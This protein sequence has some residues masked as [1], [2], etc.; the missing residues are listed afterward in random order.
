[1]N[2]HYY[3]SYA[4]V[5]SD[6]A[7]TTTDWLKRI[8]VVLLK[9][10]HVMHERQLFTIISIKWKAHTADAH[11]LHISMSK[12]EYK[13]SFVTLCGYEISNERFFTPQYT[14]IVGWCSTNDN[15]QQQSIICVRSNLFLYLHCHRAL[16][17]IAWHICSES[18]LFWAE[19]AFERHQMNQ[20][21][22]GE[23]RIFL[24]PTN[25]LNTNYEV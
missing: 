8:H 15:R 9:Q 20:Q 3:Y 10:F 12:T 23:I 4:C 14:I 25:E 16:F 11:I 17:A 22:S 18:V 24:H 19:I 13:S 2:K 1:M 5:T 21:A 6:G 7:C